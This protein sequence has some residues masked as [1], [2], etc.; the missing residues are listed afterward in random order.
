M[1]E[2]AKPAVLR[3]DAELGVTGIELARE[4]LHGE[5]FSDL[6]KRHGISASSVA[7]KVNAVMGRLMHPRFESDGEHPS[8]FALDEHRATFLH[9]LK[10]LED[11]QSGLNRGPK[12]QDELS[13]RA[14]CGLLYLLQ[15]T[16]TPSAAKAL[17][18]ADKDALRRAHG[19]GRKTA[20][21]IEDWI[22]RHDA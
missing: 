8:L 6:G 14:Y 10:A 17:V 15:E 21:E 13:T 3:L 20:R 16:P 11:E 19:I 7:Y 9:R 5:R 18:T 2:E 22:R 4:H 1:T 12:P